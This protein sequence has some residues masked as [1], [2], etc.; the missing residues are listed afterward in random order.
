MGFSGKL[1]CHVMFFL[2]R[3]DGEF[4]SEKI[5]KI[6]RSFVDKNPQIPLRFLRKK[7]AGNF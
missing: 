5:R 3:N 6:H 2:V 4:P 7:T 1:P